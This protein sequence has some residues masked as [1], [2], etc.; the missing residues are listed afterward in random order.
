MD[1][2]LID[3]INY[4]IQL[5]LKIGF[6]RDEEIIEIIDDEFIEED[7]P[8]E[9]LLELFSSNRESFESPKN[10]SDDFLNLKNAFLNLSKNHNILAIHNAGY[11]VEEGIADAFELFTHL[12]NNK[13]EVEGF[14][15]YS[16]EDIE[17]A[18]DENT[19]SIAFGDFEYDEEK[20]LNIAKIVRD[21]LISN[22]FD[23]NWNETIDERIEIENFNWQKAYE[24]KEYSMDGALDDFLELNKKED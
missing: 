21:E 10:D 9:K 4:E 23:I 1:K 15:F 19:L 3:E 12:R 7:I 20:G 2:D 16:F 24:N 18:I 14:C 13:Y 5:L 6:Y 22:G 17:Q 8:E 11:D